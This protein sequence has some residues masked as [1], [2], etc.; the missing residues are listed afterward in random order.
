[1]ALPAPPSSHT[2]F[3]EARLLNPSLDPTP[4]NEKGVFVKVSDRIYLTVRK[5]E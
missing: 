4:R 2:K 5:L 3:M 1:M